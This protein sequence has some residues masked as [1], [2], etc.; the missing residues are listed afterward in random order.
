M[1]NGV[2][3]L[4]VALIISAMFASCG[5]A[6]RDAATQLC[7]EAENQV[8]VG[9]YE[10]AIMVLDTLDTHYASEVEVRRSA[11]KYRAM[12]V[13]GLTLRR[14][15]AVDDTLAFLK[16][17]TDEFETEFE[18]VTNPG[19]GLGGNFIAKTIVKVKSDI[20]PRINDD[21]YFTLSV[22]IPGRSI[23]FEYIT[24]YDPSGS[25]STGIIKPDRLV[26]VENSEMTVLQQEDVAKAME[27]L[28]DHGNVSSYDLVGAK[29]TLK[30][31]LT[32]A[33]KK[34]LIDT[35]Q[36]AQ[37]KQ[38]YRL[39]LIEREKLERKLQL[40]RDQLANVIDK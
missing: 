2:N 35:W 7:Q 17:K 4:F 20:L 24:F 10:S 16:A 6:A 18:Y 9:N 1:Y 27:W 34:A 12:A 31:K 38:S 3:K 36:Y 25:A 22:K 21:G 23:G 29:S 26:K 8:K 39:A 40:C 37:A 33:M 19:K 15:S 32:S 30:Q 28:C 5:N 13:E 11:M 14:I